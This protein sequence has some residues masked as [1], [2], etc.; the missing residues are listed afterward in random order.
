M[1]IGDGSVL[2]LSEFGTWLQRQRG[3]APESVRCYC[4]QARAFL[5][6]IG[7]ADAVGRP[8]RS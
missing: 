1:G 7:G 4:N 2:L 6:G 5:A 8:H 3:L